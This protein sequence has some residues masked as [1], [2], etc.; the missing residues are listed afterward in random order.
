MDLETHRLV[1]TDNMFKELLYYYKD[2]NKAL[3]KSVV[4]R[5]AL[6]V[7]LPIC[8]NGKLAQD[9]KNYLINL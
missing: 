8:N 5:N 4:F 7:V 6:K 2:T 1:E 9:I 3:E